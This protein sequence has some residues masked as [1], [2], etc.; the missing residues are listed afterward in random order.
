[1]A[2]SRQFR[3]LSG[4]NVNVGSDLLPGS[5]ERCVSVNGGKDA[6]TQAGGARVRSPKF[7]WAPCHLM[8]T[9][10]LIG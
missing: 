4:A 10:V 3:E 8:C 5:T 1:M 9:A 7:I 6:V 2:V